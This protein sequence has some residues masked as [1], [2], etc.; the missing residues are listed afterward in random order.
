ML[1]DE[2]GIVRRLP[3]FLGG[4]D[5]LQPSLALAA[6]AKY[7]RRPQVTEGPVAGG[8]LPLA[9][10]SIPVDAYGNMLLNYGHMGPSAAYFSE[11]SYSDVLAGTVAPDVF[12]GK[13]ALIG[14][15]ATGLGDTFWTPLGEV[16]HGVELHATAMETVLADRFLRPAPAWSD[17]LIIIGLAVLAG[18][19][20][21]KLRIAWAAAGATG[22]I[23]VY[24]ITAVIAF[25]RGVMM[26]LLFPALAVAAAAVGVN[27]LEVVC[28][29]AENRDIAQTFG[30]YVS[31]EIAGRILK[32]QQQDTLELQ[33]VSRDITAL[34]IDARQFTGFMENNAPEAVFQS[35]NIYMK[36]IIAAIQRHDGIVN[37]FAGDGLLAVWN[38]PVE[39]DDHA[40]RAVQAA[41]TCQWAI[42]QLRESGRAGLPMEFGIGIMS[43]LAYMG[44]MGTRDRMEY[45][46]FGD[47][48]NTAARLSGLVPG[49]RIWI[50]EE[51]YQRVKGSFTLTEV[52][53]KTLRGRQR[54]LDVYEVQED[55]GDVN[56]P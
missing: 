47:A 30:R 48:V 32:A 19:L 37:K 6:V 52:G 8:A 34:Y 39:T 26:D 24:L 36:A 10:R 45:S 38:A 22:L 54:P 12:R 56:N 50:G 53:E 13:I 41:L 5:D 44:T 49:N 43:G 42:R 16:M 20:M 29:R 17:W 11:V 23:I 4:A 40:A 18:A 27:V 46:V 35:L 21:Q 7:L 2:D 33:G 31:P 9:G 55:G 15:T 25:D 51:T 14:V 3:L 28:E 1:P